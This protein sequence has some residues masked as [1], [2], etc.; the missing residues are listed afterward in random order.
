MTSFAVFPGSLIGA[1]PPAI[2]WVA[3]GRNLFEPQMMA[4]AIF[5]FIWQIPHFWLL[6]LN[7]SQDYE[8]AGYPS[9]TSK[10]SLKQLARI[11]FMWITG[12]AAACLFIPLYG[13]GTSL[14]LMLALFASAA[15]LLWSSRKLLGECVD[16]P[17]F[18]FAFRGVNVYILL[19]M[20]SLSMDRLIN[21]SIL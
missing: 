5:F 6:L 20:F 19:V 10:F 12:T 3:G 11:T 7:Y 9:L 1:V 17:V 13:I 2:G 15:Y 18:N 21:L 16:R 8:R 14:L 4:I